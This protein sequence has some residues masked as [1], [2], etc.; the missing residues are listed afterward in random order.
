MPL[1][2]VSTMIFNGEALSRSLWWSSV[3][4][5]LLTASWIFVASKLIMKDGLC[6]EVY[7]KRQQKQSGYINPDHAHLQKS[8]FQ[9]TG[10]WCPLVSHLAAQYLGLCTIMSVFVWIRG[11]KQHIIKMQPAHWRWWRSCDLHTVHCCCT[12]A[13]MSVKAHSVDTEQ[14]V[15]I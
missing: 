12:V 2:G 10:Y 8:S 11:L 9:V 4:N 13:A 6:Y 5:V 3:V 7:L 15:C 1:P 14:I